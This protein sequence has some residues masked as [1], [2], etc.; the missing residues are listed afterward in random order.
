MLL[1]EKTVVV[2]GCGEIGKPIYQLSCG[3]FAQ[4]IVEDP[5]YGDPEPATVSQ[6]GLGALALL[7]MR[8]E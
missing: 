7:R 5:V 6:L 2:A 1:I 3:A 8:S 4:V